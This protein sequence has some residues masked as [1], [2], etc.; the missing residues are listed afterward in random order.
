MLIIKERMREPLLFVDENMNL[1]IT[2]N[3]SLPED[4]LRI[5]QEFTTDG[6]LSPCR[7]T[8]SLGSKFL[9]KYFTSED[10]L[11]LYKNISGLVSNFLA[12]DLTSD[13]LL[14]P[15]KNRL[16]FKSKLKRYTLQMV[17]YGH[18]KIPWAL[19]QNTCRKI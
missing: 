8:F 2:F 1:I 14:S 10:L 12:K 11:P 17:Y 5:I 19:G 13:D 15:R 9:A 16:G 18:L 7:N 3:P 6:L 4:L